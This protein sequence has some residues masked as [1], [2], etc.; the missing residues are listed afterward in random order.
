MT[1][2]ELDNVDLDIINLIK[3]VPKSED[4]SF[5][6]M[7]GY[8]N[9]EAK[10]NLDLEVGHEMTTLLGDED[11]LST[12]LASQMVSDDKIKKIVLVALNKFLIVITDENIEKV[13]EPLELIDNMII[14]YIKREYQ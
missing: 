12:H 4:H 3:S 6:Y 5:F 1:R 14:D 13:N 11:S 7:R 8:I 9:P 2:E 10:D